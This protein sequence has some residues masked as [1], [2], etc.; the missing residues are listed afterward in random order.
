MFFIPL[1]LFTIFLPKS[2]DNSNSNKTDNEKKEF[3]PNKLEG[4]NVTF[5]NI[6]CNYKMVMVYGKLMI[7]MFCVS[8]FSNNLPLRL[9][10][11]YSISDKYLGPY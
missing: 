3:D 7:S 10:D 1:V 4:D 2:I 6:I 5:R 9:H 11:A 8:F